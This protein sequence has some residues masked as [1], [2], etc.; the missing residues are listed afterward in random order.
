MARADYKHTFKSGFKDK[1]MVFREDKITFSDG[2]EDFNVMMDWELP[3]MKHS[4]DFVTNG[5]KAQTIL[6][7][8]FGMGISAEII[9]NY[10]PDL[11]TIIEYHPKIAE[12]AQEFAV[13]K[14]KA[15]S[16]NKETAHKRVHII[17]GKDWFAEFQKTFEKSGLI[18]Y[19]GIFIDTYNDQN[20][21]KIKDY[22]TKLL[23]PGGNMTW[24]NPMQ[25][26]LPSKELRKARNIRY[27]LIKLSEYGV[28]SIPTN[29]YH[30]TDNYYMPMYTREGKL[31]PYKP[32]E[33]EG[34]YR[35]VPG[36]N[37]GVI[38]KG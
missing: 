33:G 25:D 24:W 8:G 11:H 36:D 7:L 29:K 20:L 2:G 15:Y 26:I 14:N 16:R 37:I 35:P 27:R 18:Q 1:E 3:I 23:S 17:S 12:R 5:G 6:E 4:A 13:E 31:E 28:K 30:T 19:H 34:G 38:G 21:S 9:Q 10:S 22:I 32:T